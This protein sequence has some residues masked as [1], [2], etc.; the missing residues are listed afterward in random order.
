MTLMLNA[1]SLQAVL[2]M[3]STVEAVEQVFSDVASGA[4]EQPTPIAMGVASADSSFI[5]MPGVGGGQGLASVKLLADI[6]SNY[7]RGLPTQRSMIMLSDHVTGEPLA[8][9][10]GR[11]PTRIR[12]AAATA[13]ATR[14]LSRPDS[15]VL[16]LVGAGAL[17]VA[18][19][20]ALLYVRP[21]KRV[22]VWS[23]SAE[24][25]RE[26][27]AAIAHHDLQVEAA[28][29]IE[30]VFGSSDIVCTLTPSVEPIV[31]G[32]WFTPGLHVNAVGARPRPAE[33]EIDAIGMARARVIL[34][35]WGTTRAKSGAYL[36]AVA[37]GL[38][39]A[40]DIV[41]EL[42]QVI[43]GE[44]TGRRNA[45]DITLFNSVG[46]GILDLAIGRLAY[47]RALER[48]LGQQM[49]LAL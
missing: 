40:D 36:A 3:P 37:E 4:A 9:L 25:V 32:D 11:V 27:S 17:A 8:V 6:P 14:H 15:T 5:V 24:R 2:D 30:A 16:G 47:D 1:S 42:G 26:F 39:A 23:R 45:D 41:G 38:I 10:D 29:S 13:V 35:H 19:V 46:V 12:T 31:M 44:I 48:G 18:H 21:I 33:R 28:E 22:V 34:D 43:N 49:N 7:G 20:E